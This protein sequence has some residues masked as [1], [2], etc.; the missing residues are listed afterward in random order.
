MRLFERIIRNKSTHSGV[1]EYTFVCEQV[2]RPPQYCFRITPL[3]QN[4]SVWQYSEKVLSFLDGVL[5]AISTNSG[6]IDPSNKQK[7][8]K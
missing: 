5:V 6:I 3:Y 4:Q 1:F 2:Q 7:D 8:R